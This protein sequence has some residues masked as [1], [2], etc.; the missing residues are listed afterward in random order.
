MAAKIKL[1]IA[2]DHQLL[3]DGIVNLLKTEKTFEIGA[4]ASNGIEVLDLMRK[5]KYD[6]CVLDINM[7]QMN[8]IETAKQIA[9]HWSDVKII[10]LTTH[11]EKEFI[12]EML[13]AGVSGYILKNVTATELIKAIQEVVKGNTYF[14]SEVQNSILNNYRNQIKKEKNMPAEEPITLT[15]REIEIVKLLAQEYTNDQIADALHISF[16]TVETHRKNIMHKTK[17]QN[18]A[19]L[20]RYAY[21]QGIAR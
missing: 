7:P 11:D 13:I 19:G 10:I 2:D 17:A 20:I 8:G 18:I 5:S 3:L 1:L 9:Q 4:T 16:R 6:V 15:P 21:Q 14:S 12:S